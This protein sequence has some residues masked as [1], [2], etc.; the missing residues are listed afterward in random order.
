MFR[1]LGRVMYRWRVLV[2]V[3]W[4]AIV[5]GGGI[6]GGQIF[7]RASN[8]D[9]LSPA[10]ESVRTERVLD[11]RLGDGPEVV[12]I[13]LGRHPRDPDLIQSLVSVAGQLRAIDGV[14]DVRDGYTAPG[15]L[16][17][18]DNNSVAVQVELR[19]GLAGADQERLEED[20]AAVLRTIDAPAVLV[21]G[22]Q[23][24]D[25]AFADQAVRDAAVGES[26]A[27]VALFVTLVVILGGVLAAVLPLVV[28][29]AAIAA[30]FL[31]LVGLT[32]MTPVSEFAIN[33]VTLL[34]VGLAVDYTIVLLYRFREERAAEPDADPAEWI[35]GTMA[36]A[37]RAVLISGLAVTFAMVGLSVFAE[38]L[39]ASIAQGGAIV[40]LLATAVALTAGPALL[41]VAHRRVPAAD[42]ITWVR[43]ITRRVRGVIVRRQP[44][45]A[46][47]GMLARL[48]GYAQ[49][50]PGP[51]AAVATGGLLVLALPVLSINLGNSDARSL[52][53]SMEARQAYDVMERDFLADRAAPVVVVI[54][55]DP[56][57]PAVRDLLNELLVLPRVQQ[58][59]VRFDLPPG[60]T[61]VDLTP[62][63][64]TG[65]PE[66]RELVRE[67][68]AMSLPLPVSVGGVAAEVV[69]HADSLGGRLP[70]VVGVLLVAT[71]ALLFVLTGS[72]VIPV[73]AVMLNLLTLLAT[74]GVLVMVFQR[75]VGAA[76]LGFEPW[77]AMD[78]TTPVFLLVFIYGLTMDYEVF[79]LSRIK[80]EHDRGAGAQEVLRGIVR[81]GPVVT[82]AAICMIIVFLGFVLGELV[83]VKE[84]GLGM[85]VAIAL[86]VTVVRGLLL[87]A[88][89][90]MLGA[91]N[92][93]APAPLRRLHARWLTTQPAV[94]P[95]P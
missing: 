3:L 91:W 62:V 81:S 2:L 36:T 37:G 52:P 44:R 76:L 26:I 73:K 63:G 6:I 64:E 89:M 35:G 32:A 84:V 11:E 86:D 94:E 41:G 21:S 51:V 7:D 43:R 22:E 27:L 70:V 56:A 1:A 57:E 19:H 8:V 58:L 66:S 9:S 87:P 16:I 68:R 13:A 93:W 28:A 30:A 54:D 75:G 38:P 10:A 49:R 60:I 85:A 14:V 40:A 46:E 55:A 34:G 42:S 82:A 45:A 15:G 31:G 17:G 20:V 79:M 71:M 23:L 67:I 72:V 5:V 69:D 4:T 88:V 59:E 61:V 18:A 33:V 78:L 12:A 24:A 80:E 74:L 53:T 48:A 92:W 47:G 90:S 25:R 95:A 77:G 39:L 29:L 65:G 50:R 83:A